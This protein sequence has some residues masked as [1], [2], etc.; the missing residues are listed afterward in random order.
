MEDILRAMEAVGLNRNTLATKLGKSRQY[1]GKILDDEQPANFTIDTLAELSAALGVKLH[2][3]MLPESE[4]MIFV[5]GL[6]VTTKVE[7][8]ADFPKPQAKTASIFEDRFES[9][10]ITPFPS[11]RH[12]PSRLSS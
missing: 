4:H 6:T 7:P 2:V 9:S 3:R 10:N 8:T 12:D 11:S 5:R 1:I